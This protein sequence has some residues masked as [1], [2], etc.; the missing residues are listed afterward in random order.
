MGKQVRAPFAGARLLRHWHG[1][2]Q[3]WPPNGIARLALRLHERPAAEDAVH[4][5]ANRV[6]DIE[7]FPVQSCLAEKLDLGKLFCRGTLQ[8]FQRPRRKHETGAIGEIDGDTG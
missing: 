7:A 5:P 1:W 8:S 3:P 2:R 4:Q 6:V